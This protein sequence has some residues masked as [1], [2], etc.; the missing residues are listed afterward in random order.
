M[1]IIKLAEA[2]GIDTA[3]EKQEI[4]RLR[5]ECSVGVDTAREMII[6]PKIYEQIKE[7]VKYIQEVANE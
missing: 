4:D 7:L 1:N 5:I 2:L 6:E 3:C